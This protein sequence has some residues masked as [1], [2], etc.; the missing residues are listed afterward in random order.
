MNEQLHWTYHLDVLKT[1][2]AVPRLGIISDFDGTLSEFADAATEATIADDDARALDLL[3]EKVAL[4]ALVSGRGVADLRRRFE[5][6]WLRYYGNHGLDRWYNDQVQIV[7]AAQEWLTPLQQ[8]LTEFI[9]P[10]EPGVFVEN[11][12]ATATVHYRRAPDPMRMRERLLE[13]LQPL[14]TRSGFVLS[15]GRY[16]WEIKP[17]ISLNKATAVEALINDNQ[18]DGVV[19]LGD[20]VT[21]LSAM[22]YLRTLRSEEKIQA[23]SVGVIY[24]DGEPA[25]M[26]QVCDMTA[27]GP[28]DVAQLLTWI[29]QQLPT[30]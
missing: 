1:V 15:E 25:G 14:C 27:T 22:G 28:Q 9:P 6:P 23:V 29:A 4:V 20:D 26:R 16:I 3:A 24:Q 5:R 7:P 13:A 18:L 19:F 2:I 8:V 10:D 12:G 17:P 11:K 21:D 30:P